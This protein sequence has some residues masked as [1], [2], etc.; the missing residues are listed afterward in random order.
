MVVGA[1]VGT[2]S[3]AFATPPDFPAIT[4][5]VTST[6][7]VSSII[8]IGVTVLLAGA[9]AVIGFRLVRGLI[10]WMGGAVHP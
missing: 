5:P 8:T 4:L 7:I 3:V 6:S 9:A 10:G 1:T 2:A